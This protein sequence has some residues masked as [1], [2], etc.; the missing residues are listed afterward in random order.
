[1]FMSSVNLWETEGF[2]FVKVWGLRVVASKFKIIFFKKMM[3]CNF[4]K[5]HRPWGFRVDYYEV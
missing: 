5:I 3:G 4:L 1:M 2:C